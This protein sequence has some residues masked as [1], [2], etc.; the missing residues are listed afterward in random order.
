[1]A[2]T[3]KA[4]LYPSDKAPLLKVEETPYPTVG[5]G[6]VIVKVAAAAINPID[7]K[8]QD[9]GTDI[10]PFL[11]YPLVGGLD[12]AGT[13]VAVSPDVTGFQPSDRV[14][15][16]PLEFLSRNGAFQHYVV[17]SASVVTR[18]PNSTPFADAAVLPSGVATAAIALFQYL[19]LEPP[20]HPA[21]PRNG[22][23]VFVAGGASS[24]GSNAIQLAVA[25]GY[26]VITTASAKNFAHCTALGASQVFD[27][28]DK[29]VAGD[30]KAALK[31]KGP[32]FVG[33]LSC[34]EE[35]NAL[36]FD[37]VSSSEGSKSVACTILF[38]NDSVPAGVRTEMIHAHWI[39]DTPLAATIFGTFLPAAL[40]A[41]AYK[42]EPKPRVVGHGLEA[43]QAAFDIGKTY[44]VSCEKLVV[45]L[46]GG[47]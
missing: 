38:S 4:A 42:C 25:S 28:H 20:T 1:M 39:K 27:Y 14:L 10:L 37:I 24:V 18:I 45:T 6:E 30:V 32:D 47:A 33:A 7:H 29:N 41:G 17:A 15:A 16:F 31:G 34:V 46:E 40:A 9:L 11:T 43:V 13:I 5:P 12:A 2:P 35:S 22:K 8:A 23:T 44:T 19:G 36:A 3:N 21:R 26:E